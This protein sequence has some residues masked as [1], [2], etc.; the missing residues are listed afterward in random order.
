MEDR[1]ELR[2]IALHGALELARGK[3]QTV[4]DVVKEAKVLHGFLT[5]SENQDDK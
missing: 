3:T 4:E 5:A 1:K 2:T